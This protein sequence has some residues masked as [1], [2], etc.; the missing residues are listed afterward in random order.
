MKEVTLY[1]SAVHLLS[2]HQVLQCGQAPVPL[3]LPDCPYHGRQA[4]AP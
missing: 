2:S 1:M 3:S 4:V